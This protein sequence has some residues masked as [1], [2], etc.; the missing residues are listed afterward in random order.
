M[1]RRAGSS[2]TAG[3]G[4]LRAVP[5]LAERR[6]G[7]NGRLGRSVRRVAVH[8]GHALEAVVDDPSGR[9]ASD[10]VV[11][12]PEDRLLPRCCREVRTARR[13]CRC[14]P[15]WCRPSTTPGTAPAAATRRHPDAR[16]YPIR[17]R[18]PRCRPRR[19]HRGLRRRRRPSSRPRSTVPARTATRPDLATTTILIGARR[20][21]ARSRCR[22]DTNGHRRGRR[23]PGRWWVR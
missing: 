9:V 3:A 22:R 4:N 15:E 6:H 21:D 7:G 19:G 23:D 16:A 5:R 11:E 14:G 1:P 8:E 12:E 13:G 2:V 17:V 20:R 18:R 10:E